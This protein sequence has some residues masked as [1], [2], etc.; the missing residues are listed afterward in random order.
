MPCKTIL[1]IGDK[2]LKQVSSPVDF[3]TD[4]V[5]QYITDLEDTLLEFQKR[6]GLGRAIAAP[7]IAVMKRLIVMNFSGRRIVL[8]NPVITARSAEMFEVWDSCFSA[9]AA[10]FGKTLRH[11]NITIEYFNEFGIPT[12]QTFSDDLS[13]L[14]QHEI[15]HLDGIL[16]TDRIINNL[17]IMR[18]E[19]EKLAA[20]DS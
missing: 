6:K 20:T 4:P 13:E 7:Q 10:F 9:D 2:T 16:F 12:K 14:F 15:D 17:I 3:N 19:W 11:K 1:Q 18:S 5:S 8:I